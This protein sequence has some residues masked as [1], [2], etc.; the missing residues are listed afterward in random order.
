MINW[1]LYPN[2]SESEFA[3]HCGC[4]QAEMSPEFMHVLQSI[5]T[6]FGRPMTVTSGYRCPA[7]NEKI[8]GGPEHPMGKAADIAVS[9]PDAMRLVSI[10]CR[11]RIPRIGVSQRAGKARF[12]HI[13]GSTDLPHAIWSY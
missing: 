2:F 9:N 11:F 6:E 10:A 3:C 4:G 7:H 13:G 5:R 1:S 12:V 8:G